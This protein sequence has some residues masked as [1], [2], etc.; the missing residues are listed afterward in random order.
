MTAAAL[1]VFGGYLLGLFALG[2][3]ALKRTRD[4]SDYW[5]AGGRLGWLTGG[6]T[7]AATH[8][9]AGTF[10]GAVG[11]V[12]TAGWSLGWIVLALPAAYWFMAGVLAPRFTRV[13][14]LTLPAFLETR[15]GSRSVRTVGA[16]IILVATVVY[17][18][19]QVVAG[20][21][22]ANTL[23]G[24]P[25]LWGMV[26]FTTLM[27]VY[28]MVG[29]MVAV[30][31]TDLLQL[32]VM[33]VGAVA[34]VPLALRHL[35]GVEGLLAWAQVADPATFQWGALPGAL[36]FTMA[37]AFT[38]GGIST[39]EKLV[40]LYAMRDMRTIRRGVLLA[41][42]LTTGLNLTVFLL[43]L[44]ARVFFPALPTG[45]LAMP[46]VATTVLPGVLGALVLAAVT[47]A[48]MSTV[49]S[50][51]LVAGSA[52]AHDLYG[53][54][55]GE[56]VSPRVRMWVDRLGI[57]VVGSVPLLLLASGVGEGELVQFIVL[58]FS[59]LMGAAFFAPVVL[60]VYWARA[61][62]QGA[63]A[64]MLGGAGTTFLWETF[65]SQEID[66]VLPGVLVS[67]GLLWIV[68]LMTPP[69]PGDPLAPYR[70]DRGGAAKGEPPAGG[71]RTG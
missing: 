16:V 11:L 67:F 37:L 51:L 59:A 31:Y 25:T 26:G 41:V 39:P 29:G 61:N 20:G 45:D 9:S 62:R 24:I 68:S 28:T 47:A 49:D 44:S 19:A 27:V 36:L 43:A 6:A 69:A 52:L 71:A 70:P 7:L 64:S 38:L 58:L 18:Q 10:I 13:R 55:A 32:A 33:T 4:E 30:V 23:F 3:W 35:D 40:R 2:W 14:E 53:S 1:W 57:V 5:I 56:R 48:M 42:V 17:I 60:G 65:G 8:A 50:L 46:L 66:P 22:V 34:A 21:L 12:Y 15:Y 54:L 63:L